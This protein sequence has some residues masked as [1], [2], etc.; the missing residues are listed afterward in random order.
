MNYWLAKVKVDQE[1]SRGTIKKVTEQFVVDAV[2]A[3]DAE[4]KITK[5]YESY[6]MDW[7]IDTL[8][9]MRIIKIIE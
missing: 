9:Q 5:E 8:K 6:P 7:E 4:V 2:N 3:T 1:T